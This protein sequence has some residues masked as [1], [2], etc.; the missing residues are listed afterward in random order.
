MSANLKVW[1]V[2]DTLND[3]H[4][5]MCASILED[6][7]YEEIHGVRQR[8]KVIKDVA[9]QLKE[10]DHR[11]QCGIINIATHVKANERVEGVQW[12]E[13]TK[14]PEDYARLIEHRRQLF[15]LRKTIYD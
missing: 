5:H 8:R 13:L 4:L 15:H 14:E 1:T 9:K 3:A 7:H 2:L 12:W 11:Y 6:A 10:A